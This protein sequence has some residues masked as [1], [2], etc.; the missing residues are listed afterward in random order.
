MTGGGMMASFIALMGIA[1]G[2]IGALILARNLLTSSYFGVSGVTFSV[3]WLE[4][5]IF[6]AVAYGFA[7]LMTW[8]P[9]RQA[10]RTVIAEALRYE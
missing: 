8:W 6:I 2:V 1:S 4:V 3:P 5:I 7:L 10:G 9:S